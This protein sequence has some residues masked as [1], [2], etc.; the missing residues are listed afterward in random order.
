M[1]KDQKKQQRIDRIRYTLNG[2]FIAIVATTIY[3]NF[4][5]W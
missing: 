4:W 1:T 2:I 3:A 5:V